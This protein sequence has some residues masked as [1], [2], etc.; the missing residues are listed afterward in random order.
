VDEVGDEGGS[1]F[2]GAM[3]YAGEGDEFG[4]EQVGAKL[5]RGAKGDGSV[6]VAPYDESRGL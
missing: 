2:G 4:V 1:F 6:A 3:A 5:G